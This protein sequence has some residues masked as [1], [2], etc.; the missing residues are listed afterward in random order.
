LRLE[1]P[2]LVGIAEFVNDRSSTGNQP[3][4]AAGFVREVHDVSPA[5][6]AF[7]K[8]TFTREEIRAHGVELAHDGTLRMRATS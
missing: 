2:R 8:A 6:P 5:I 1:T 4:Q 3:V 7:G